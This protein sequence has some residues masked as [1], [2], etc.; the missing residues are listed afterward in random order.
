MLINW[1]LNSNWF[2][3]IKN[4]RIKSTITLLYIWLKKFNINFSMYFYAIFSMLSYLRF[5]NNLDLFKNSL[6]IEENYLKLTDKEW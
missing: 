5:E 4:Y 1:I 6:K 2:N 3:S